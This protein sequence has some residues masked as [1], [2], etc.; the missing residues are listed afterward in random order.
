M[1]SAF[2]PRPGSSLGERV[3]G[4]V[5][6]ECFL[7][8]HAARVRIEDRSVLWNGV[9]LDTLSALLVE[10]PL[11]PWPQPVAEPRPGESAA[12]LQR[13][14]FAARERRALRV[15]ALRLLV[16]RVR[17]ANDPERAA[18][19]AYSAA[20]ALERLE[21]AKVPVRPW[22]IGPEASGQAGWI[23]VPLAAEHG[24][25]EARSGP[26]FE[27]EL[28]ARLARAHLCVGDTWVAAGERETALEL[29]HARSSAEP[30]AAERELACAALA[31][32]GLDF[33][34]VHIADGAVALVSSAPDL[35]AW[36]HVSDGRV[37]RALASLIT[38][39]RTAP[40]H[41]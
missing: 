14:G 30:P 31:A 26:C 32:L 38:S 37:A 28:G 39:P 24:A 3:V 16:G 29:R 4:F 11:V 40:I 8:D 5:E 7:L 10:A 25:H 35:Q 41:S 27:I 19:L 21:L 36:D 23:V 34:C 15:S 6:G 33:G 17:V 2:L 1:S 9:R 20:L 12:E 22:R 13:R 18:E